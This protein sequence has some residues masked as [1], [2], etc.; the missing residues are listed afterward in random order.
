MRKV[1][2]LLISVA[3]AACG[4]T[5][6]HIPEPD[7]RTLIRAEGH[8]ESRKKTVKLHVDA[9]G[10]I[11]TDDSAG[12]FEVGIPG[13]NN[14]GGESA[15]DCRDIILSCDAHKDDCS[16]AGSDGDFAK[17]K[18]K[19][20]C[21]LCDADLNR[22]VSCMDTA[23]NCAVWVGQCQ[24][25]GENGDYARENCKAACGLCGGTFPGG[26]T[27][28]DCQDLAEDCDAVACNTK[29]GK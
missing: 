4:H 19:Q 26:G 14:T 7:R 15:T 17:K 2:E 16:D 29:H 12:K 3:F 28:S 10:S 1:S 5:L 24:E 20:T 18:C 23:D 27:V 8:H 11:E 22:V 21:G 13:D 25:A 6:A 9:T